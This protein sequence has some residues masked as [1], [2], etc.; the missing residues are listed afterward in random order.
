LRG[1]S[2]LI[3]AQPTTTADRPLPVFSK[4]PVGRGAMEPTQGVA[5]DP[6]TSIEQEPAHQRAS[7]GA[8]RLGG[9]EQRH[10]VRRN[11]RK[12]IR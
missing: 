5:W 9:D 6:L 4:R 2:P 8:K 10:V 12:A 7:C 3:G 11:A 1:R